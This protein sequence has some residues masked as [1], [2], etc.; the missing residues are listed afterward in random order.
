MPA[1]PVFFEPKGWSGPAL[2]A[3]GATPLAADRAPFFDHDF[4]IVDVVDMTP[5]KDDKIGLDP[6]DLNELRRAGS[7]PIQLHPSSNGLGEMVKQVI[8]R[9]R[10][11]GTL[12]LLRIHGHGEAGVQIVAA[13]HGYLPPPSS[14]DGK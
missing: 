10:T 2:R 11:P 13:G 6:P 3:G 5:E 4:K 9:V 14:C 8:D 12:G 7:D 1:G